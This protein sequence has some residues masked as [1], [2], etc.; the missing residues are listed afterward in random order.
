MVRQWWI[1][2]QNRG[3][4]P[5]PLVLGPQLRGLKSLLSKFFFSVGDD[6]LL[7]LIDSFVVPDFQRLLA[8]PNGLSLTTP[9]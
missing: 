8:R 5:Q 3:L 6:S 1:V 4:L 2:R 9:Q 7:L